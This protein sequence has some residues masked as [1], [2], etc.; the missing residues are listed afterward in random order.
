MLK[1]VFNTT[2]RDVATILH[3]LGFTEGEIIT[4]SVWL[5]CD[6]VMLTMLQSRALKDV[7]GESAKEVAK[8][9]KDLDF[10]PGAIAR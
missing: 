5:I 3:D 1:E 2:A 9:L 6:S 8:I 4:K 7:F 10:P